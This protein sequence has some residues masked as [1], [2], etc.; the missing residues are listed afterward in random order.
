MPKEIVFIF[1][2]NEF[3]KKFQM[4]KFCDSKTNIF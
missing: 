2:D 1:I 3:Y 4:F